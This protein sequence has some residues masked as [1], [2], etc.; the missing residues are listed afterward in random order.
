M[1]R[2]VNES[3]PSIRREPDLAFMGSAP[4]SGSTFVC[5]VLD[6]HPL[7]SA[8]NESLLYQPNWRATAEKYRSGKIPTVYDKTWTR[9]KARMIGRE[10]E[11][12]ESAVPLYKAAKR[13]K[14][15]CLVV[16]EKHPSHTHVMDK[17]PDTAEEM[18]GTGTRT[19]LL[20][21]LR[22]PFAVFRSIQKKV[23]K[24]GHDVGVTWGIRDYGAPTVSMDD[25]IVRQIQLATSGLATALEKYR[26]G[27]FKYE[28]LMNFP[29]MTNRVWGALGLP[30]LS[31]V[32]LV[33]FANENFNLPRVDAWKDELDHH[34]KV[35]LSEKLQEVVGMTGYEPVL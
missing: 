20:Y 13:R 27:M 23:E 32:S 7:C 2:V 29:T 25:R 35:W 10:I 24:S 17:I 12:S 14:P 8:L 26:V 21:L 18:H 5:S 33:E 22:H 34:R 1:G 4:G 19:A 6:L 15:G 16:L 9:G 31:A 11:E 30:P 3:V 28:D